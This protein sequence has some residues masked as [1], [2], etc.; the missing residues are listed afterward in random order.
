MFAVDVVAASYGPVVLLAIPGKHTQF[1]SSCAPGK[2]WMIIA[3][4][5]VGLPQLR[6]QV[7][8]LRCQVLGGSVGPTTFLQVVMA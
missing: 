2:M 3:Q 4:S 6:S 1:Q 8:G 7:S 5:S